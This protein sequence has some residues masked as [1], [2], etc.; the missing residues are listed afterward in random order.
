MKHSE[1]FEH[2]VAEAKAKVTEISIDSIADKQKRGDKF[3]LIDVREDHEWTAGRAKGAVHLSKGIIER[4]IEKF[5]PD[6]N[7]E[8][9]LILRWWLSLRSGQPTIYN[10]WAIR[11]CFLW[12]V[13]LEPG[14]RKI[15][16]L[17]LISY[18]TWQLCFIDITESIP[19][20]E[21]SS[22]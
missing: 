10:V 15:C 9:C 6:K 22:S 11:M 17:S 16:R 2:L 1:G 19:E 18:S 4:D 20:Q 21:Y 5:Y 8:N 7:S 3:V 12:Q 13:V 14:M